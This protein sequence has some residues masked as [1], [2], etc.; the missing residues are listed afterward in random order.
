MGLAQRRGQLG[1]AA[2]IPHPHPHPG[3]S[4]QSLVVALIA[5]TRATRDGSS[6][7]CGGR[8]C[9]RWP[10]GPGSGALGAASA[11]S[12]AWATQHAA[13]RAAGSAGACAD[14]GSGGDGGGAKLQVPTTT[15]L[16]LLS[17]TF[18][19]PQF[20]MPCM[21]ARHPGGCPRAQRR[22]AAGRH[23]RHCAQRRASARG[24]LAYPQ[25]GS[26]ALPRRDV[27][28]QGSAAIACRPLLLMHRDAT[29]GS[30]PCMHR[31][32][33]SPL[34]ATPACLQQGDAA[35]QQG[36]RAY[37]QLGRQQ[38]VGA[39]PRARPAHLPAVAC[40]AGG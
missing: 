15:D 2:H 24:H 16:S 11:V 21:Q 1:S 8:N 20:H 28:T 9:W 10:R 34:S 5:F 27:I 7:G 4:A 17:F 13:D 29:A 19:S 25:G 26:R 36:G 18:A 6:H 12:A 22:A 30:E 32:S 31:Q 33:S 38:R 23:F 37:V 3:S 40:P 35:V 39:H 14:G